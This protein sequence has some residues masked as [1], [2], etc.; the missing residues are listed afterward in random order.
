VRPDL[1]EG[2]PRRRLIGRV[3]VRVA[4]AAAAL[5]GALW[6]A[7]VGQLKAGDDPVLR[8]ASATTSGTTSTPSTGTTTSKTTTSKTTTTPQTETQTTT[9]STS[10]TPSTSTSSQS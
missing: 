3:R 2:E 5:L 7:L 9:T 4:L 10:T 1:I 8:P 6:L